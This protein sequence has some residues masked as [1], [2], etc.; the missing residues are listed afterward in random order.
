MTLRYGPIL[1]PS[2]FP[3]STI[4]C[5]LSSTLPLPSMS[6]SLFGP[7]QS[8]KSRTSTV[9]LPTK[10]VTFLSLLLCVCQSVYG[11][12]IFFTVN[13]RPLTIQRSDPIVWP[14]VPSTRKQHLLYSLLH[15]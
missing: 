5:H 10:H 7:V 11:Q 8:L 6:A 4:F 2:L 15:R 14:G 13:C 9:M 3:L 12:N 1:P